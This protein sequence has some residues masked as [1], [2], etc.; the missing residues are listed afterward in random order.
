MRNLKQVIE[1]AEKKEI[2][3]GH[4]N[5]GTLEYLKAIARAARALHLPVIIGV[6][7]GEREYLGIHHV[8]DFVRSYNEEHAEP[9]GFQLFLNADHTRSLDKIEAAARVGFD[10]VLFDGSKLSFEENARLTAEAVRKARGIKKDII[11]EG[12]L[13]YIGS[14]SELLKEI[15]E[16]AA[17]K[18]EDLT[19][20]EEA[21]MFVRET[22]VD[23][24]APA[25]GNLH[26]MF[27]KGKNPKLD[28]KRIHE[29][30]DAVKV[31]LVLHGGSGVSDEDFISAIKAGVRII[32]ISTELRVAWRRELDKTL[33]EK[34]DEI[35]PAKLLPEVVKAI[36]EVVTNR[37]KLFNSN[38]VKSVDK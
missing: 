4:F 31:P 9:D 17:I 29:I 3:I 36:E 14:S 8:A 34:P 23:L 38:L 19:T 37:L 32:H 33:K 20:P 35:A 26:G 21:E 24:F 27:E 16:G 5:I 1:E 13:G 25:V 2:A 30:R 10:A 11:T 7:E 22:G 15:P 28:I 18:S 6:S 12:E